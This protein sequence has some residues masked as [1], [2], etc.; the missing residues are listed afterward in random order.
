MTANKSKKAESRV[1]GL[2]DIDQKGEN[3]IGCKQEFYRSALCF[4]Q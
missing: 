3:K 1:R 4:V 2:T